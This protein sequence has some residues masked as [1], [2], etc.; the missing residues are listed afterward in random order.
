MEKAL[1]VHRGA[2]HRRV[3]RQAVHDDA[4]RLETV[5][6]TLQLGEVAVG[7]HFLRRLVPDIDRAALDLTPQIDT[8]RGR[9]PNQLVSRLIERDH[10]P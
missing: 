4:A 10:Q 8:D 2:D 3:P 7:L 6:P 5:S 9:V 1:Q